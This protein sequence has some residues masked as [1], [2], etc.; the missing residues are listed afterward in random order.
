MESRWRELVAES[1]MGSAIGQVPIQ[2]RWARL[3]ARLL[4]PISGYQAIVAL[5]NSSDVYFATEPSGDY[6]WLIGAVHGPVP[7]HPHFPFGYEV[8]PD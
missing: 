7:G 5:T 1:G 2:S 8:E 3:A 4:V 6:D